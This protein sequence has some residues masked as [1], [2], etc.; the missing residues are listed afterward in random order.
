[1][2]KGLNPKEL[3]CFICKEKI[4]KTDELII[5]D[6]PKSVKFNVFDTI[7]VHK[8]HRGVEKYVPKTRSIPVSGT[9]LLKAAEDFLD[10][11]RGR[12]KWLTSPYTWHKA[13]SP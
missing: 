12:K 11:M 8:Y 9:V 4:K 6:I 2:T 7:I 10:V 13:P 5:T 1:M 3:R